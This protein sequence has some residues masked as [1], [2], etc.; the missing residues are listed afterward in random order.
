MT[1]DDGQS[2]LARSLAPPSGRRFEGKNAVVTGGRMGVGLTIARSL[3][4]EGANVCIVDLKD[5][6]TAVA[7]IQAADSTTGSISQVVCDITEEAAVVSMGTQVGQTFGGKLDVLVNNAG[8]NGKCQ[9]VRDMKVEDWELT[10][11]IN[12]TGTMMV[13][14]E[15]IPAL[16][17][18]S[19]NV[20]NVASNVA[21]RGL[22]YRADYVC[23]KWAVIGLTQTLALELVGAGVRVNG[24]CP[25][26]IEGERIEQVMDM[27]MEAEGI[28]DYS[29]MRDG[30]EGVPMRRFATSE[31]VANAIKFL[32]SDDSSFCTGQMINV[33]G[34]FIMT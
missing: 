14:R 9:L 19:G 34:G 12:L 1:C 33:T 30:W 27:H 21:R 16:E 13:T 17:A 28:S 6:S 29:A 26:P 10:L 2:D 8:Y 23:S 15:L 4:A 20:A 7:A 11:R 3:A 24:V 31:E 22:P 18:A 5:A 32:V 25:G